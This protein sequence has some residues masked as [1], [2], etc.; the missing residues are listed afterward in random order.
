MAMLA[1]LQRALTMRARRRGETE[2][3]EAIRRQKLAAFAA[4]LREIA[5]PH[6]PGRERRTDEG[7]DSAWVQLCA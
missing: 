5:E 4:L 1:K 7:R 6:E 3:L 2:D